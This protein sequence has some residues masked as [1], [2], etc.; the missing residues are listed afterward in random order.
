VLRR[1]FRSEHAR[2]VDARPALKRLD[3]DAA[4]ALVGE[5]AAAV[6]AR[7]L[8]GVEAL[9]A[10]KL[11]AVML[12]RAAF[13]RAPVLARL[14]RARYLSYFSSWLFR[15]DLA[16][17]AI[18]VDDVLLASPERVRLS[19]C[20]R[21]PGNAAFAAAHPEPPRC[22]ATVGLYRGRAVF[23]QMEFVPIPPNYRIDAR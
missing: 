8:E 1:W 5:F 15:C 2:R 13:R 16:T 17:Y 18:A 21:F 7:D 3:A 12:G 20:V 14:N 6:R 9:F 11:E 23:L 22:D 19:T 4:I 10:P